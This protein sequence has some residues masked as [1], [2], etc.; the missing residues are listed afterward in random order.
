MIDSKNW[1]GDVSITDGVL[2]Q[3]KWSRERTVAAAAEAGLAVSRLLPL[4]RPH[5]V[6]PVLCFVRDGELSGWAR[7]VMVCST[8]NVVTM[9]ASRPAVLS[10]HQVNQLCLDLDLGLRDARESEPVA[11]SVPRQAGRRKSA[12]A[13]AGA[14]RATT[15]AR[16]RGGSVSSLARFAVTVALMLVVLTMSRTGA[17]TDLADGVSGWFV[18]VSTSRTTEQQPNQGNHKKPADRKRAA[19]QDR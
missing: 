18:D 19:K 3:D 4:L 8:S 16:C 13:R 7:D 1:S 6:H 11:P 12:P 9:L 14:Q 15:E 10:Q 5:M 17:F 2:R